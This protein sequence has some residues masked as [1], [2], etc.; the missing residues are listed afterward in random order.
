MIVELQMGNAIAEP[1]FIFQ[2]KPP[3]ISVIVHE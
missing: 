2:K 3:L 1:S